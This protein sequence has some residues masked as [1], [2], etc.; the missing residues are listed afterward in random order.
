MK[1]NRFKRPRTDKEREE[2][3]LQYTPL[4]HKIVNQNLSKSPLTRE[5]L[6]G[7]GFMGLADAMNTYKE[8]GSQTFLQYA[9]YRIYYFIMNGTYETGHIV[10]FS[11]YQQDQAK[12]KGLP[13][14]ISKRLRC[15]TDDNGNEHWNIPKL[16]C[17]Q[18][19]TTMEEAMAHLQ[20]F[21]ESRF[22]SRDADVFFSTFGLGGHEEVSGV[23]L[24]K[25]YG[26][27]SASI[28]YINQRIIKAIRNDEGVREEL[29]ELLKA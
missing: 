9:A 12:K 19:M 13:T 18:P 14:F 3:A 6:L 16:T 11:A 4:V 2:Y 8:G 10:R 24:A 20:A 22:S 1:N 26:V 23:T 15:Y 27:T 7:Y 29:E 28:T 25:K 5:D 17:E 21:V